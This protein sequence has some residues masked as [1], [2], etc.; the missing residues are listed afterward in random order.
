M[1]DPERLESLID[2]FLE[3]LYEKQQKAGNIPWNDA[4]ECTGVF[5]CQRH[6]KEKGELEE[7]FPEEPE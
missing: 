4:C 7:T 3:E 1:Q 5:I 6:L 2:K